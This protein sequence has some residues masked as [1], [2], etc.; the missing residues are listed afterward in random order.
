MQLPAVPGEVQ[1]PAVPAG[2]QLPAVPAGVQLPAV[3]AEVHLPAGMQLPAVPA[4]MQPPAV[5]VGL[6]HVHRGSEQGLQAATPVHEPL[7][8]DSTMCPATL[9]QVGGI[10]EAEQHT[11]AGRWCNVSLLRYTR[12]R[13]ESK[14]ESNFDAITKFYLQQP[15]QTNL[16]LG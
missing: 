1:M 10:Q 8:A 11:S 5:P 7:Q 6:R 9:H 2:M 12:S 14:Q 16:Q 4:G 15:V 3:P 13:Y